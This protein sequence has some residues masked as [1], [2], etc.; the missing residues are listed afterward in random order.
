MAVR[1]A[2]FVPA[3]EPFFR[4]W[5]ARQPG[6]RRSLARA[7][8][9][10]TGL[11]LDVAA[12]PA[13]LVVVGSKGKGTTATYASA[14]LAASG[15]RVG[16][17]TSPGYRTNRERI[18]VNGE[19][20]PASDYEALS[21][22]VAAALLAVAAPEGGYLSPTGLFTLAGVWWLMAAG[23]EALVLEAGIG[24]GSD[25]VSLFT[26]ATVAI[27][28]IF[29]EHLGI[30]GDSVTEIAREK[31]AVVRP[32]TRSVLTI[33]QC[34]EVAAALPPATIVDSVPDG[35]ALPAGLSGL[36]AAL[37]VQAAEAHGATGGDIGGDIARVL[38][39]VTLP[40]RLSVHRRGDQSFLVDSAIDPVGVRAALD[41]RGA[42][43][44]SVVVAF[45]DGKRPA[46]CLAELAG[47]RVVPVCTENRRL[48]FADPVW[49]PFR[50]LPVFADLDLPKLGPRVLAL[51][52]ISFVGEVLDR[53]DVPTERTF[54]V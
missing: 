47:C 34:A 28:R 18:R 24:G 54:Q 30:L 50:P 45:P 13:P 51:G 17:V 12:V 41:W 44:S 25:E 9:Y 29:D 40:G 23:C 49:D 39:T 27:T 31:A 37:G 33:P 5:S 35:L 48:T 52:T 53:L 46:A 8:A 14:R 36:N 4:E 19:A 3:D 16:T 15:V 10:A 26:P 6:E 42:G 7:A 43:L 2:S 1:T 11:G 21:H 38:A 20:I 32:G 22:R